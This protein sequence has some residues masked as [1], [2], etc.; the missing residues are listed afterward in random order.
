MRERFMAFTDDPD[1]KMYVSTTCLVIVTLGLMRR[2]SEI[3]LKISGLSRCIVVHI[4]Q[5]ESTEQDLVHVETVYCTV[6]PL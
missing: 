4:Q 5:A 6:H 3:L 2:G 1:E